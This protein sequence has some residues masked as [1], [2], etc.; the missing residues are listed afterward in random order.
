MIESR[1]VYR[2]RVAP[3]STFAAQIEVNIEIAHGQLAQGAIHR[4]AITAPGE[5][6]FRYRAPVA[7]YFENRNDV[8]RVLFRFQIENQRRESN[9][10]QSGCAKNAALK[11]GR[12]AVVQNFLW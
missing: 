8:I 5:I 2:A 12:G 1:Q 6:R 10:P 3:Q 11:A 7:A 9:D 4:F